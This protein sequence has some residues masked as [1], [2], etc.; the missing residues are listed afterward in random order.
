MGTSPPV[1]S[2]LLYRKNILNLLITAIIY[3]ALHFVPGTVLNPLHSLAC[4]T[5]T[6]ILWWSLYKLYSWANRGTEGPS[7]SGSCSNNGSTTTQF[8]DFKEHNRQLLR[9]AELFHDVHLRIR[10]FFYWADPAKYSLLLLTAATKYGFGKRSALIACSISGTAIQGM[11][12]FPWP[13]LR[14]SYSFSRLWVSYAWCKDRNG[15]GPLI[16]LVFDSW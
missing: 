2:Y 16:Q 12:P 7:Y 4:S 6:T 1:P 14:Q 15:R 9:N 5:F 13:Q 10:D 3:L 8:R 11:P